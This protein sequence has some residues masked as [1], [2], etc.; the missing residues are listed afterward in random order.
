MRVR[1]AGG[2]PDDQTPSP[3]VSDRRPDPF[4]DLH[5]PPAALSPIAHTTTGRYVLR[6]EAAVADPH[7][8]QP[9]RVP[10]LS[11]TSSCSG[12]GARH[13]LV[14]DA[15][16][17]P[18][19]VDVTEN[20]CPRWHARNPSAVESVRPAPPELPR[21]VVGQRRPTTGG[22]GPTPARATAHRADPAR[23][24]MHVASHADRLRHLSR[25]SSEHLR[26]A[27]SAAKPGSGSGRVWRRRDPGRPGRRTP[28]FA[29]ARSPGR[30]RVWAT[31]VEEGSCFLRAAPTTLRRIGAPGPRR[32]VGAQ[33]APSVAAARP[34]GRRAER[35]GLGTSFGVVHPATVARGPTSAGRGRGRTAKASA[36]WR[37]G[38]RHASGG[39][40]V[41]APVWCAGRV[42]SSSTKLACPAPAS[43]RP[44]RPA[45]AHVRRSIHWTRRRST[46]VH[47]PPTSYTPVTHRLVGPRRGADPQA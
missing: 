2:V 5:A 9:S 16:H 40:I 42:P 33:A 41:D 8:P 27:D 31:G 1:A 39:E 28:G 23:I 21:N 19:P 3:I 11:G 45:A 36:E 30:G 38:T 29:S 44:M 32:R 37:H 6:V 12:A 18:T 26:R 25:P 46:P 22:G 15:A 34:I 7:L 4:R 20:P 24:V 47:F 13:G 35:A 17:L 10:S 14:V 43:F